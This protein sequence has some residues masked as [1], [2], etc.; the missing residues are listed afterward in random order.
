[1]AFKYSVACPTLRWT[2]YDV[3]ENPEEVLGAIKGAGYD[4]A[5]L[6]VEGVKAE[7]FRPIVD[8]LGLEVPE[9]MGT[10]GYVHSGVDRDLT[11]A[12]EQARQRG[13]EYSKAAIELAVE[14]GAKFFNICAS[15]P[16][17]PQVPFPKTPV[18][19]LRQN[20]GESL[21][22]VCEYAAPRN[23]TILLEP[24]NLY[25]A[26]PGVLTSVYDA[27][28]LI[29]ELG[30]DNLGVQPDVFHMNVSESSI[31][32]AVRAAGKRIRVFHM[33]ETNHYRLGT[34]HA[35][36]KA[37]IRTLKEGGFDGYV[38]VYAPLIS[39]DVFQKKGQSP[40]RPDLKT[41]LGG[42]LR[43]LKEVENIVDAERAIYGAAT[44]T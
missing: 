19:T 15:Q 42:Q 6:P 28:G 41:A 9:I 18:A 38:T 25:E 3:R 24:L 26:L 31:T 37:I 7:S 22:T 17:V 27:I 43:F 21:R 44:G 1:M 16:P 40:D 8:S 34:G 14:M 33:N 20:F 11:S 2:G 13:I 32:S 12:D 29:D 39:E 4:G 23:I 10:W 36:Y 5:D 35:D 30:L